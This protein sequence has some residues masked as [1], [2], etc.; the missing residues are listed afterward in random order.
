MYILHPLTVDVDAKVEVRT[1][2]LAAARAARLIEHMTMDWL[3]F[4]LCPDTKFGPYPA[5][6]CAK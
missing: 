4:S 6:R 2:H 5:L 3:G 1:T